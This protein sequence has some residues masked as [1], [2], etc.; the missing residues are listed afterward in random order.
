MEIKQ[1]KKLKNDKKKH[2]ASKFLYK[3]I[4]NNINNLMLILLKL[5]N[6]F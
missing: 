5:I 1:Q 2:V 4:I 3:K 6:I